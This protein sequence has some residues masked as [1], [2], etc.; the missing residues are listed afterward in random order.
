MKKLLTKI[1]RIKMTLSHVKNILGPDFGKRS[2]WKQHKNGGGWVKNTATVDETAYIGE[3]ALVYDT[4]RVTDSAHVSDS[5]RV[6]D[7]AHVSGFAHVFCALCCRSSEG[8]HD[9][10]GTE[11]DTCNTP[12]Y[13]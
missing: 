11:T 8:L 2:D 13:C 9:E 5:A 7:S 4:A 12:A 1:R 6:Y 3:D 10:A